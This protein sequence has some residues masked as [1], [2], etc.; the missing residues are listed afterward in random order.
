M[1]I[2]SFSLL[3]CLQDKNKLMDALKHAS[4]MLG[5]LRTSMLSPKS[6]YELCILYSCTMLM[7]MYVNVWIFASCA[8]LTVGLRYSILCQSHLLAG[9]VTLSTRAQWSSENFCFTPT[10]KAIVLG[11]VLPCF[12]F[13][14]WVIQEGN[15]SCFAAQNDLSHTHTV[16]ETI[17]YCV[18]R[19]HKTCNV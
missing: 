5:E 17:T 19:R 9:W 3:C 2:Q 7:Y 12:R 15:Q 11:W 1:K 16:T 13:M 8:L 4:N 14:V 18:W 6:Y 10:L